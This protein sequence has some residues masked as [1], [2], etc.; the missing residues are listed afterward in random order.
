MM[1]LVGKKVKREKQKK[2][3]LKKETCKRMLVL[4]ILFDRHIDV[5]ERSA[6]FSCNVSLIW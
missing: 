5:S 4:E 2:E 6:G 1:T 3:K